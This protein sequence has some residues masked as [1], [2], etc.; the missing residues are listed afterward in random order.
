MLFLAG[1]RS[2]SIALLVLVAA[3]GGDAAPAGPLLCP[4]PLAYPLPPESCPDDIAL[5]ACAS[6]DE[7]ANV[8][9]EEG[10]VIVEDLTSYDYCPCDSQE[11]LCTRGGG[12]QAVPAHPCLWGCVDNEV[13]HAGTIQELLQLYGSL[14]LSEP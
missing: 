13:H 5:E 7:G 8:W 6:G 11:R 1:V 12:G 3:C 2:L 14:C 9:C 4:G 10:M